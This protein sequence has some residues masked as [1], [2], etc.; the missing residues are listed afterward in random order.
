M[1]DGAVSSRHDDFGPYRLLERLGDAQVGASYLA[2]RTGAAG[3]EKQVV[4]RFAPLGARADV[5]EAARRAAYLSQCNVAQVLDAG[6]AQG[7]FFVA[8]EHVGAMTLYQWMLRRASLPWPVLAFIVAEA[9]SAIAYAHSRRDEQGRLL[10]I[11]HRRL[12]PRRIEVTDAGCVRVTG[13]G[14][15]WAWPD[16]R[17]YGAP[18]DARHEP[19]DGRADVYALGLILGRGCKDTSKPSELDEIIARATHP[20]PEYRSTGPELR[21]ALLSLIEQKG[22]ALH[23]AEL[24]R[25]LEH[26]RGYSP[27]VGVSSPA[28][29][30]SASSTSS[31]T[32]SSASAS[33]A[34]A[35]SASA[36]SSSSSS[37]SASVAAS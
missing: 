10:G 15:V 27:S 5:I 28:A 23:A 7:R 9:S 22:E 24:S 14:T 35:A 34:A 30:A 29:S 8:C 17:G 33:A 12:S 21:T 37:S 18:E 1:E 11:V 26:Y 3:F 16:H 13:F 19:V 36:A 31:S 20:L 32:S 2:S 6:R 25:R 4:L